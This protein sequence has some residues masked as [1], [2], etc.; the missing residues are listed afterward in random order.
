MIYRN[1]LGKCF[2]CRERAQLVIIM[3]RK[4]IQLCRVCKK[5]LRH[6]V[7]KRVGPKPLPANDLAG[8]TAY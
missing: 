4:S 8:E 1:D 7:A 3:Y 2:N 6:T 5:D